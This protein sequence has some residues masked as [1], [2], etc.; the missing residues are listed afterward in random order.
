MSP[1]ESSSRDQLTEKAQSMAGDVSARM[2][3]AKETVRNAARAAGA[4]LDDGRSALADQME[5]AASRVQDNA[6]GMSGGAGRDFVRGAA[7]RIGSTADYL[8]SHDAS[9]MM[10]DVETM[11]KNNPGPALLVAAAFGFVLARALARD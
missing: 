3:D 9:R 10:S 4:R 11:V 5:R 6:D 8:R 2:D 7:D 1:N